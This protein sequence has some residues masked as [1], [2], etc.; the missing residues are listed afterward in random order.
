MKSP[1]QTAHYNF[2]L[3]SNTSFKSSNPAFAKAIIFSVLSFFPVCVSVLYVPFSEL[4]ARATY[5]GC[6]LSPL[7]EEVGPAVPDSAIT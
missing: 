1:S 4:T 5:P 6:L 3:P 2:A 7:P